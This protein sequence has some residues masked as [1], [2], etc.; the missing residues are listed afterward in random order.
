MN[1]HN[2]RITQLATNIKVLQ[3]IVDDLPKKRPED[4]PHH[5]PY[6]NLKNDLT[7]NYNHSPR[8]SRS[9]KRNKRA[10]SSIDGRNNLKKAL[11]SSQSNE[12]TNEKIVK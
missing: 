10:T 5:E 3:L 2:E 1:D 4:D 8:L 7:S 12:T 11:Q 9:L 6:S